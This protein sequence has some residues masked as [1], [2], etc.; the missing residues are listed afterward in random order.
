MIRIACALIVVAM[1]AGCRSSAP[2]Y[3]PFLGRTTVE[4]PGTAAVAPGAPPYYTAPPSSAVGPPIVSPP[5]PGTAA[6]VSAPPTSPPPTT[7]PPIPYSVPQGFSPAPAGY[8]GFGSVTP[9]V[10]APSNSLAQGTAAP[11]TRPVYGPPGGMSY[12]QLAGAGQPTPAQPAAPGLLKP[13]STNGATDIRNAA[14][15]TARSATPA[16]WQAA[17]N[18]RSASASSSSDLSTPP[19]SSAPGNPIR[20]VEPSQSI[21]PVSATTAPVRSANDFRPGGTSSLAMPS[22]TASGGTLNQSLQRAP[23]T[24]FGDLPPVR[25]ASFNSAPVVGAAAASP[26]ASSTANYG[27]DSQ[28]RWVKGKLEYS[29]S[30]R[31]WRLRYIPPDAANDNYGGSMILSDANKL[32]GFQ[33]GDYVVAYGSLGQTGADKGSFAALYNVERIQKQ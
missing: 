20:I 29:Q 7:P 11:G 26:A 15:A 14:A 24:E 17:S 9:N 8:G 6:P 21:T 32:A 33:H 19:P 4:P 5:P 3:D 28:Y 25:T 23:V 22:S 30:A 18:D 27:Y 2:V 13:E 10:S 31:T 12:P 1:C 16:G